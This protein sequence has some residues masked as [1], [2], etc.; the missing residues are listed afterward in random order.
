MPSALRL[1][2]F[3]LMLPT[4]VLAA[5]ARE[6]WDRL[7]AKCHGD[8]GDGRTST[9]TRR[10]VKDYTDPKI[11]AA[12]TDTGLLKNLLLGIQAENGE[13]RMPA[14]K[15]KLTVPEAKDLVALIR[16]FKK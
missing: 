13:Y 16:A 8:A 5:P 4:L 6:N 14:F 12:F 9:G 15:D 2:P 11:Q 3:L 1:L 7:C 10:H